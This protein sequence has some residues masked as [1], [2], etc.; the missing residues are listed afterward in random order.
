MSAAVSSSVEIERAPQKRRNAL[1]LS[2]ECNVRSL[3]R[4]A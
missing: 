2:L 1:R 3:V 4:F